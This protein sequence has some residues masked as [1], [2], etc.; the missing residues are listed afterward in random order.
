[1]TYDGGVFF[2]VTAD[3]G[4]FGDIDEVAPDL[5]AGPRRAALGLT[6]REGFEPSRELAPPTRLAGECLQPLGHLSWDVSAAEPPAVDSRRGRNRGLPSRARA[7]G[8]VAEWLNAAALK[9]VDRFR[10]SGGSNPSPSADSAGCK[11]R[12]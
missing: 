10:R 9:A 11:F 6:E 3:R 1:M 8:G 5:D 2:A 4:L 12:R 7:P